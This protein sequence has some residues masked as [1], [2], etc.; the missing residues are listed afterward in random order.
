MK[1]QVKCLGCGKTYSEDSY[2]TKCEN[3]CNALLRTDY[4]K[5]NLEVDNKYPG[6]WKYINWLPIKKIDPSILQNSSDFSIQIGGAFANYLGLKNLIICYNI[7]NPNANQTMRTGTFKDIEAEMSFQRLLDSKD[8][9]K[10]LVV[11]SD[12]NIATAFNYYSKIIN[13]PVLLFITEEARLNRV[14]SFWE[15]NNHVK[16]ISLGKGYDYSDAISSSGLIGKF[17]DF[18]LEGGTRNVARRDGI[19]TI[20][21]DVSHKL[22]KMPDHYF[23]ALGSGPGAIAMYEASLRLKED[24]NYGKKLPKIHGSQNL[25]F[26]PMYEAW[27]KKSNCIDEKYKINSAKQMIKK[28]YA[29]VLTNRFPHYNIKGGVFDALNKTNGEFYG[30]SNMQAKEAKKLFKKLEDIS[31]AP[32]AAVAVASLIC[33]V[34]ERRVDKQDAIV[35][36]ITGGQRDLIDKTIYRIDPFIKIDKKYDLDKIIP[37]VNKWKRQLKLK[38]NI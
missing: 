19:G 34:K 4:H 22:G 31:I 28:V 3:G 5:K 27:Q 1:F 29:H 26:A 30:I 14:W 24:G 13:Y 7:Y 35:L 21:L 11:S 33:A 37:E 16:V 9:G 36:N 25:P 6:I 10:I 15:K 17:E 2:V 23:Q 20:M 12:G 18:L 32:P 38:K 8:T